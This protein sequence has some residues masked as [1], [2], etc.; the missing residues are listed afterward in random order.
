MERQEVKSSNIRSI[1][2]E[3]GRLHVE[4]SSGAVY[5]YSGVPAEEHKALVEAPSIGAYFARN[6]RPKYVGQKLGDGPPAIECKH[7]RLDM[8]GICYSCG[9][10]RRGF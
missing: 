8:D 7:P 6:I 5:E 9:A 3:S 10:D 1:G 4:F 2:Y